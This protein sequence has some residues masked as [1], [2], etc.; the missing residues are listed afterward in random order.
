[1]A[2]SKKLS[3]HSAVETDENQKELGRDSW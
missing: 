1:M 3:H 2:Y